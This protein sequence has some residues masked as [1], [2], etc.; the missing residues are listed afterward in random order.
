M[1]GETKALP[2]HKGLSVDGPSL[3]ASPARK[4][5]PIIAVHI[6]IWPEKNQ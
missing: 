2:A 6:I 5:N 1:S 3:I 4:Q